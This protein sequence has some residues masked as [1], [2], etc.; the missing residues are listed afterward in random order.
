MSKRLTVLL[1]IIFTFI[2]SFGSSYTMNSFDSSELNRINSA[3]STDKGNF[4]LNVAKV[5]YDFYNF[6]WAGN[7]YLLRDLEDIMNLYSEDIY[8]ENFDSE[9]DDEDYLE[10]LEE[11]FKSLKSSDV[12]DLMVSIKDE[13]KDLDE[14]KDS[15]VFLSK[16]AY[17][18]FVKFINVDSDPYFV[19]FDYETVGN[20]AF[21]YRT[22]KILDILANTFVYMNDNPSM[23]EYYHNFFSYFESDPDEEDLIRPEANSVFSQMEYVEPEDFEPLLKKLAAVDGD[24]EWISL[25]DIFIPEILILPPSYEYFTISDYAMRGML[26]IDDFETS[27]LF[28]NKRYADLVDYFMNTSEADD[29]V[30]Y[31][32]PDSYGIKEDFDKVLKENYNFRYAN[33]ILGFLNVSFDEFLMEED[34]EDIVSEFWMSINGVKVYNFRD[35]VEEFLN[36][37]KDVMNFK[38]R[39][40]FNIDMST[41]YEEPGEVV[42]PLVLG[43]DMNMTFN[44][45]AYKDPFDVGAMNLRFKPEI[46][47]VV[48]SEFAKLEQGYFNISEIVSNISEYTDFL[49]VENNDLVFYLNVDNYFDSE[50]SFVN[51]MSDDIVNLLSMFLMTAMSSDY[52]Y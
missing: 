8:S 49:K 3:M 18:D 33:P 50:I 43:L 10:K 37:Y 42:E 17:D 28:V 23:L 15:L 34:L 27:D 51:F 36:S 4:S 41:G 13:L 14:N 5:I 6:D 25:R 32:Y 47:N 12:Y 21:D 26:L 19:E 38:F 30:Y 45:P 16:E 40:M 7:E 9:F 22:L 44:Y 39:M 24:S 1:F 35:F 29:F 11:F 46:F 52:N 2:L 48:M 20:F 31:Y